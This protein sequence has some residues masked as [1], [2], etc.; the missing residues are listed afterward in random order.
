MNVVRWSEQ[1]ALGYTLLSLRGVAVPK[2][3]AILVDGRGEMVWMDESFGYVMNV[4]A[5]MYK[6]EQYLTFWSGDFGEGFGRGS[7]YIVRTMPSFTTSH[8]L[9][10][11]L[12]RPARFSLPDLP[13]IFYSRQR[14]R[15]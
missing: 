1:C 2:P 6:G 12:P 4:K 14:R 5:Q 11:I 8:H 13:A 15:E 7:Y 9:M 3:A 10:L